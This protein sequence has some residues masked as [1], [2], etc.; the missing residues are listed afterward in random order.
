MQREPVS[1]A[2]T[3]PMIEFRFLER[4][5]IVGRTREEF[6]MGMS[7]TRK[8]RKEI[9]PSP[10]DERCKLFVVIRKIKEWSRCAVFLSLKQ[11]WRIGAKE[12]KSRNRPVPAGRCQLLQSRAIGRVC[13][14][15]VI[16]Y[17]CDKRR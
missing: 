5:S 12:Q 3:L 2:V 8:L 9:T 1:V 11:H 15:I 16:L 4:R 10:F 17:V 6:R 7:N 13:E 14:L